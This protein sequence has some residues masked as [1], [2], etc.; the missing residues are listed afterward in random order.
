LLEPPIVENEHLGLGIFEI[1]LTIVR[2]LQTAGEL[3]A[4]GL[5]VE[6]GA[7]EKGSGRRAHDGIRI[8]PKI[9]VLARSCEVATPLNRTWRK[10][11]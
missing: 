2:A 3:S 10:D 6:A 11:A 1:K 8:S 5:T 7:I 9:V 4:R